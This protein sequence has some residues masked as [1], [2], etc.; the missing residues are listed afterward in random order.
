MSAPHRA[1]FRQC[2]FIVQFILDPGTVLLALI[3]A[4]KIEDV[5]L[6][7]G[8]HARLALR[9]RSFHVVHPPQRRAILAQQDDRSAAHSSHAI[10]SG[11]HALDSTCQ[12]E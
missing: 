7:V 5:L 11:R 12:R 9:G 1:A 10:P 4:E 8:A 2:A 3:Y 6:I